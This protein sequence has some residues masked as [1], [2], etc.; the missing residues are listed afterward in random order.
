MVKILPSTLT[1]ASAVSPIENVNIS[2]TSI[3]SPNNGTSKTVSSSI[4][5]SDTS[6]IVGESL[7]GTTVNI[8]V[9]ES[10]R[11]PSETSTVTCISPLKLGLGSTVNWSP[12]TSTVALPVT[13]AEYV[14]TSKSISV[15]DN[16]NGNEVSSL[17]FWSAITSKTG[18]S[19]TGLTVTSKLVESDSTPSFT[20]TVIDNGPL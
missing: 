9:W 11:F 15:A 19:L 5:W 6:S 20:D 13:P 8:N 18:A 14:S 4:S 1:V 12:L 10:V 7:T 2:P 16:V 3:S 17:I